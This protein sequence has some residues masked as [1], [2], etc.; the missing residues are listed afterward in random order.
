[1][2]KNSFWARLEPSHWFEIALGVVIMGMHLYGAL[3]PAHNFPVHWFTRDDAYY[4][5]KVAQNISEGY[6]STFDR[7]NLTNGYHPLW[8][9]VCVPI[10]SL[11]RIDIILPLRIMMLVM[12]ALSLATAILLHRLLKRGGISEPIAM[13]AAAYWGL[14][15]N[16]H[17]II[18]QQGMETGILAFSIAFFLYRLQSYEIAWRSH[19]NTTRDL[20]ELSLAA[21]LM[22]FS[23]LDSIYLV[24]LAGLWVIFRGQPLRLLLGFDLLAGASMIVL[25]YALRTGLDIYLNVFSNS[26]LTMM[27]ICL[28][29]QSL[30]FF[31]IGL[32]QHPGKISPLRLLGLT[33][34]AMGASTLTGGA[35]MLALN[36]ANLVLMPRLV[37]FIYFGGMTLLAFLLRLGYGSLSPWPKPLQKPATPLEELQARWQTWLAESAAYYLPVGGLLILYMLINRWMFG[38]F[39]PVS[40]QIKR[41]WGSLSYNVYGGGSKT[42]ADIFALDPVNSQPWA[43]TLEPIYR[44]ASLFAPRTETAYWVLIIAT[45]VLVGVLL[46]SNRQKTARALQQNAILPLFVAAQFHAFLYGAVPYAARHEWYWVLQMISIVLVLSLTAQR[47][48]EWL[49]RSTK[50]VWGLCSALA[51]LLAINF[52]QVISQRMPY[53]DT[54]AGNPYMDTLPLLENNTEPGAI[55]GMTGGGNV[56]YYIKDRTIVNMD[57]LINS[58]PYFQALQA[59]QAG[60]YLASIGLDYV[61]AN[62]DILTQSMPYRP[63]FINRLA[64]LPGNPNYGRKEIMRFLPQSQVP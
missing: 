34:L 48:V 13:V 49:V 23:R 20:V 15:V 17:S 52:G 57:G 14:D 40:G 39:M 11:A 42:V 19:K 53:Q 30:F 54:M 8:L 46:L 29:A 32:Y 56:S 37:P 25:A 7:I 26:A 1:M 31:F 10:F 24:L 51:F 12:A 59:N 21:S 58:Y 38:T 45:L 64:P 33:T 9:L 2:K 63:Q 35:V 62:P 61:F 50:L 41:W 4:Y 22:L 18:T 43:L 36:Q 16:L 6:G 5:F 55:I 3:S 60:E 28:V 44:M 47:L 27:A